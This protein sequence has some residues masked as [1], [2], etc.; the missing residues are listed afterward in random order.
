MSRLF[1]LNEALT[2]KHAAVL[3]LIATD[4]GRPVD[5]VYIGNG[6][7]GPAVFYEDRQGNEGT[8][9]ACTLGS[10]RWQ[11]C[12]AKVAV[13]ALLTRLRPT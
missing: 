7:S 4:L 12:Q 5:A 6:A 8:R 10:P 2:A 13:A 1:P 3:R 9:C 11:Q